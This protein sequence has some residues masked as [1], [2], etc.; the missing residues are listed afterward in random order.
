MQ[1]AQQVQ[2]QKRK[3]MTPSLYHTTL[4][5]TRL[6]LALCAPSAR[7]LLDPLS[8]KG[9]SLAPTTRRPGT[10]LHP[11]L[12]PLTL[13]MISWAQAKAQAKA[14]AAIAIAIATA[15]Q[16]SRLEHHSDPSLQLARWMDCAKSREPKDGKSRNSTI[17][18]HRWYPHTLSYC[19]SFL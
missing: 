8:I 10:S 7:S 11:T 18:P 13:I 17:R 6:S 14:Q 5:E 3:A 4:D 9:G 2:K 1:K 19:L 15:S 16:D 12:P